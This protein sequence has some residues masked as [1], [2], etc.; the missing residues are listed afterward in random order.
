MH[1]PTTT[2]SERA[3]RV[4]SL[5]HPETAGEPALAQ[6][7]RSLSAVRAALQP[8][9]VAHGV[10]I[11]DLGWTTERIGRT[12]RVTIER[13]S[14][15]PPVDAGFGVT[16]DD[17][18]EFSRDASSALDLIDE[19]DGAYSLE[20]SSPGLDR[21]LKSVADFRRFR[22]QLAK[23]KLKVPAADGQRLLRGTIDEVSGEDEGSLAIAMSV[24]GKR[25]DVLFRN[26]DSAH[27]AFELPAKGKPQKKGD[28]SRPSHGSSKARMGPKG[29][30]GGKG[31]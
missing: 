19:L 21:P 18:A 24:D 16:I 6:R 27:L 9:A 23:V 11:V 3:P 14:E 2:P 10:V 31:R 17:C 20:V 12:L 4:P 13:L 15:A 7:E 26:I 29:R 25:H 30:R 5:G 8:L 22:G 1:I 28:G